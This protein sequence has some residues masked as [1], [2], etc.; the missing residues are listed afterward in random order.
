MTEG[1]GP[2]NQS[3][4][5]YQ[6]SIAALYVGRLCDNIPRPDEHA[7]V[8][9]RVEAPTAVD[10]IV[11]TYR[12]GHRAF[13][14]AKE[15]IRANDAAWIRLWKSFEAQF[16]STDFQRDRDLLLL[17]VGEGYEE[18][19]ALREIS[20]RTH[21]SPTP[22]EWFSRLSETQTKLLKK[23]KLLITPEHS[24]E[25]ELLELFR[26]IR[27]KIR[28]LEEIEQDMVPYWIP[29][30]NK[31]QQELFRLLR[32]LVARE[33]RHRGSFTGDGVRSILA[34]ES[35]VVFVAQPSLDELREIVMQCGAALKQHKH[36]FGNTGIHFERAV[37]KT[38]KEWALQPASLEGKDNVSFL[39]DRAGTGKTVVARD[40]L[41]GLEEAGATV[42]AIKAD[43]LSGIATPDELQDSL[44]LPDS[45]ERMIFHSLLATIFPMFGRA[46]HI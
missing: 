16:W 46:L 36:S 43:H 2:A 39:L 24:G 29:A 3:G 6:N 19:R 25:E 8:G 21:S 15:N 23:I 7:I 20:S 30:S 33:A 14:Q 17:H 4:I 18:H 31:S 10:D 35:E 28:P 1:G 44:R 13:I 26:R 12:D 9:V 27:V 5:L 42:L 22:A 38:I 32:D 34:A 41:C 37:V 40:V 45:P 11:I